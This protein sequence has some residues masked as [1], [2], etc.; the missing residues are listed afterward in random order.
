[1]YTREQVQEA[2][3]DPKFGVLKWAAKQ[4]LAALPVIE[5]YGDEDNHGAVISRT[6]DGQMW[7]WPMVIDS[8]K[9]AREYLEKLNQIKE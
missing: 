5:W 1:M 6:S 2:I 8:G 4:W 3:E 9:K 7:S